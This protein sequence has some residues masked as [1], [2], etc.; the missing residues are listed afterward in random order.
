MF[1]LVH[2]I[3]QL[4]SSFAPSPGGEVLSYISYMGMCRCV[5]EMV[6]KQFSQGQDTEIK[7]FWCRIRYYLLGN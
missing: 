1:S 3:S 5:A 4:I 2:V 7:E 6:F